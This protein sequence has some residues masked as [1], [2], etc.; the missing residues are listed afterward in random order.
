V[1]KSGH[2]SKFTL[3]KEHPMPLNDPLSAELE[4]Q[5]QELAARIR[6]R[7]DSDI[8]ALA[9]LLVSNSRIPRTSLQ[10]LDE[11]ILSS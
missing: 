3:T 2:N 5:A 7:A 6:T 9:R 10:T 11:R 4:A 1:R 8:L